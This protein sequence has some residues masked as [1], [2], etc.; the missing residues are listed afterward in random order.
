ML[1]LHTEMWV[2]KYITC[3]R[4][5]HFFSFSKYIFYI[6][7]FEQFNVSSLQRAKTSDSIVFVEKWRDWYPTDVCKR[8]R[9]RRVGGREKESEFNN[10]KKKHTHTNTEIDLV[11]LW[12]NLNLFFF[13][14]LLGAD[15]ISI[16][17]N[18]AHWDECKE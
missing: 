17:Y 13:I 4:F 15:C 8:Q 6:G 16:S 10:N 7:F 2:R 18:E 3:M 5:L 9:R 14:L 12:V 11:C 1:I